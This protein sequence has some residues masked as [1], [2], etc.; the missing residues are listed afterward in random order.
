MRQKCSKV[1][2]NGEKLVEIGIMC[3]LKQKIHKKIYDRG[4]LEKINT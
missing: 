1:S 2:Q 3:I 4:I